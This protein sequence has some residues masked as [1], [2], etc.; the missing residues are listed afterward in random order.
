MRSF[1]CIQEDAMAYLG[2]DRDPYRPQP[3]G[4]TGWILGAVAVVLLLVATF[5]YLATEVEVMS[6]SYKT[7]GAHSSFNEPLPAPPG[8]REPRKSEPI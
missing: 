7:P 2:N 8:E 1:S 5:A 4:S 3:D 6:A